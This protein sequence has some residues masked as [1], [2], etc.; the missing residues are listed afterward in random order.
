MKLE[1]NYV[2]GSVD[3]PAPD[4]FK[5]KTAGSIRMSMR[6][7]LPLRRISGNAQIPSDVSVV[8]KAHGRENIAVHNGKN[9]REQKVVST[10]WISAEISL[11]K[12]LHKVT[13]VCRTSYD[14]LLV[15]K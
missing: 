10:K 5:R 3:S 14:M 1:E 15:C 11:K 8:K 9:S 13:E 2:H 6:K 12:T 7:R 4:K